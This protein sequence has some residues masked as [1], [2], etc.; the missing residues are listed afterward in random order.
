MFNEYM[1]EL[2]KMAAQNRDA[3]V[4]EQLGQFVE[5]TEDGLVW[6]EQVRLRLKE[7]KDWVDDLKRAIQVA[8]TGSEESWRTIDILRKELGLG[9]DE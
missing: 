2:T 4:I 1:E 7:R 8:D 5:K 9:E 3:F 6:N